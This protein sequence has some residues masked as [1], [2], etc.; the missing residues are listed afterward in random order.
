[1]QSAGPVKTTGDM[2]PGGNPSIVFFQGKYYSSQANFNS[3][4]TITSST[5]LNDAIRG[6]GDSITYTS[7]TPNMKTES[8]NLSVVNDPQTG[9]QTLAMY[10]TNMN[11]PGSG[12]IDFS[13]LADP[14]NPSKG[15]VNRGTIPGV[16]GYDPH[17]VTL[18][19]GKMYLFSSNFQ[20]IQATPLLNPWTPAG[21]PTT[22]ISAP[23]G[24]Q[25]AGSLREAPATVVSG[26]KLSLVY[27]SG[28]YRDASYQSNVATVDIDQVLNPSSW[29][30]SNQPVFGTSNGITGPGSGTFVNSG[31]QTWWVYGYIAGGSGPAGRHVRAQTVGFDPSGEVQLGHPQ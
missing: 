27:A 1:M 14:S 4:V 10:T 26:N 8:P 23:P 15:F 21:P 13:M 28:D 18:P 11:G 6:D 22:V 5:N 12:S 16:S 19:N 7:N 29:K 3:T 2:G 20:N 30:H 24:S 25:G 9:K 31:N 17:A